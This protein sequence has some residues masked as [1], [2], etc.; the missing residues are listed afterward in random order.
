MLGAA[1]LI[2]GAIFL[3]LAASAGD[4]DHDSSS[5]EESPASALVMR[6]C[7][8]IAVGKGRGGASFHVTV[9]G[10][11]WRVAFAWSSARG[12][13]HA[14]VAFASQSSALSD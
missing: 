13:T 7:A 5:A 1:K 2:A 11:V 4:A 8:P 10:R 6:A 12:H 3:A 14:G 9:A